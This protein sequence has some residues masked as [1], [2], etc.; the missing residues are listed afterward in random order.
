M[1]RR[2]CPEPAGHLESLHVPEPVNYSVKASLETTKNKGHL[3]LLREGAFSFQS[4]VSLHL[5]RIW[6]AIPLLC[7]TNPFSLGELRVC[8]W[9]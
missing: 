6:E 7:T 5:G 9:L 3:P 1:Q 4:V 8:P 2:R